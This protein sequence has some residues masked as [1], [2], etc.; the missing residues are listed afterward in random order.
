MR[1]VQVVP[2]DNYRLYGAIVA[3]EVELAHKH[4]GTF[5]RSGPKEKDRA[6][7]SHANY[8]GWLNLAR[9][10]GEVVAI[11]V[12]SGDAAWRGDGRL[13]R[14]HFGGC[15]PRRTPRLSGRSSSPACHTA[16]PSRNTAIRKGIQALDRGDNF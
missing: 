9:S 12:R 10:M 13:L 1:Q 15:A 16:L 5:H 8:D 3:K 14:S 2:K 4:K 11:E 6:K 7:W